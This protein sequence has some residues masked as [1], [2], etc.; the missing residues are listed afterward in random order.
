MG[1]PYLLPI[2]GRAAKCENKSLTWTAGWLAVLG[3]WVVRSHTRKALADIVDDDH[4][5]EDIGVTRQ[6]ASREAAKPFWK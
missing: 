5:L 3:Y 1:K 4:M 6:D 2:V